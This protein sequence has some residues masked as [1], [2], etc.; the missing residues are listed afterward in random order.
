MERSSHM[1]G[2]S[3]ADFD[4]AFYRAMEDIRIR[5]AFI[6]AVALVGSG[7]IPA[8]LCGLLMQAL[9]VA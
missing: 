9:G 1:H 5:I 3:L 7:F 2:F 6:V 8:L 4:A